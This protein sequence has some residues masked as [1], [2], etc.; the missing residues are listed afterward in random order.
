MKKK[1]CLKNIFILLICIFYLECSKNTTEP[2]HTEDTYYGQTVP[3]NTPI[4]FAPEVITNNFY[5]HS[6]M[7]FSPT[8]DRIYWTT[9][10]DLVSSNR[11]LYYSDF[12]GENFS[13]AEQET[14]LAQ[15]GILSFTFLNHENH[16]VFGSLQPYDEMGGKLVRA[17]WTSEKI[18]KVW[19]KPQPIEGTVDTNWASLGSVSINVS[20]DIYFVG[21][22]EG[23]TAKIY[24]AKYENE[25]YQKFEPLQEIINTGIT[26]DPF[27]DYQDRFLLFAAAN[28]D[29]N[30][31][32]IDL[33]ISYKDENN[34]WGQP[35]NLGQ[36]ISTQYI[37][38]FPMVTRD[39]KYLFFVT[40]HSDHFPSPNTHFY[41]VDSKI[42]VL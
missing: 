37:D 23:E 34:N 18:D 11:A 20:G 40:S 16:V 8:G 41:W 17:V 3:G 5:P 28:R 10:L 35:V 38:R 15:Y 31:G 27:I 29:D 33:Y 6:K 42:L 12:D 30:I 36:E 13:T 4:R 32:I 1:I 24:C 26:L 2:E 25:S 19:T 21:R 39:G 14:A 9:F 22:M 7:I